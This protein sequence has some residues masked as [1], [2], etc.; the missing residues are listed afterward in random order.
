MVR[1]DF[2]RDRYGVGTL[3]D[4]RAERVGLRVNK[5]DSRTSED[6]SF[7]LEVDVGRQRLSVVTKEDGNWTID[8]VGNDAVVERKRDRAGVATLEHVAREL[9]A[10][11]LCNCGRVEC[12]LGTGSDGA[13]V[14]DRKGVIGRDT[15]VLWVT[16]VT[17]LDEGT[18]ESKD[19][20]WSEGDV[21][22]LGDGVGTV[23]N[24]QEG[25]VPGL[26]G[27]D[28]ARSD[29]DTFIINDSGASQIGSDTNCLDDSCDRRHGF[30]IGEDAVKVECATLNCR[31]INCEESRV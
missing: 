4:K 24:I 23:D 1:G 7:V 20:W 17:A 11:S 12:Q 14:G 21:E 18:S 27:E 22:G 10:S 29:E 9:L 26:D 28:G 19:L 2:I 13:V 15:E 5:C 8:T 6:L 25:L 16:E 31:C 3:T 30:D